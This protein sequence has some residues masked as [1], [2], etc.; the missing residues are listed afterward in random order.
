MSVNERLLHHAI[1]HHLRVQRYGA[2][3]HNDYQRIL[4]D[5]HAQ[6]RQLIAESDD[7]IQSQNTDS[8]DYAALLAAILLILTDMKAALHDRIESDLQEFATNEVD[9]EVSTLEGESGLDV[10]APDQKAIDSVVTDVAFQGRYL[11]TWINDLVQ[12]DMARIRSALIMGMQRGDSA[13]WIASGLTLSAFTTTANML[14]NLIRTVWNGVTNW[15]RLLVMQEN[16]DLIV[17]VQWHATLDEATCPI[18]AD[19]DGQI[20]AIDEIDPPPAHP[21]CRCFLVAVFGHAASL[22]AS[23][24][25]G[26]KFARMAAAHHARFTGKPPKKLRYET[27]LRNQ[28]A[29]VQDESLGPI[30]AKLFRNGKLS[31][32][33]FVSD[34]R[35]ILTLKELRARDAAAFKRAGL[36]RREKKIVSTRKGG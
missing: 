17:R 21:S 8:R 34:R 22:L 30:R 12:N 4:D 31:V 10:L 26:R 27:W 2:S 14:G 3:A 11:D 32:R 29:E 20:F 25:H 24:R 1:G 5:G 13:A 28:P 35:H 19:L 33:R 6:V 16:P 9:N 15:A 23:R 18:C 7:V 36:T